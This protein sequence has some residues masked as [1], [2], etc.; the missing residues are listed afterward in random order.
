M[1]KGYTPGKSLGSGGGGIYIPGIGI[2][3]RNMKRNGLTEPIRYRRTAISTWLQWYSK[4]DKRNSAYY[5][6]NPEIMHRGREETAPRFC[7]KCRKWLTYEHFPELVKDRPK[8][9][10]VCLNCQKVKK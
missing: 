3:P 7:H 1:R 6:H 2:V 9:L 5:G 8:R 10:T 4:Q